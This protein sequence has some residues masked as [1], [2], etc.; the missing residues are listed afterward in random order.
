MPRP[1]TSPSTRPRPPAGARRAGPGYGVLEPHAP[2]NRSLTVIGADD[3][4]VPLEE[5]VEAAGRLD[6]LREAAVGALERAP[7]A[8]GP[9]ACEA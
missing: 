8:S 4:R 6:E 2:V 1:R 9:A 7:S 3:D 5:S